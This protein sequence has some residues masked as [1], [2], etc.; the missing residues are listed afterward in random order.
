MGEI[1]SQRPA[2]DK[3]DLTNRSPIHS[4]PPAPQGIL[5]ILLSYSAEQ[6]LAIDVINKAYELA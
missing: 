4:K 6:A 1:G 5:R 3:C 2:D